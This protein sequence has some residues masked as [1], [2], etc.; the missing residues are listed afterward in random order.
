[1]SSKTTTAHKVAELIRAVAG[2]PNPKNYTS[3]VIL[4]A[5]SSVRMGGDKTKQFI[6]IDG[7]PTVARTLIEFEKAECIHEIII[8][9]KAGE[10]EL[11]TDFSEKYN[12][13]KPLRLVE[14]GET[15]Q[16]SAR[17]GSDVIND[18][19]KFICIHDAARCLITSKQIDKICH[20]AYLHKNAILALR[21]TDT[22]KIGDKS[23]FIESTTD[24]THTWQA[25]TPQV[26]SVNAYRGAAYIARDESFVATDDASMLEHIRIPV[27]LIDGSRE[28]IKITEPY[29]ILFAEAII[30]A[31]KTEQETEKTKQLGQ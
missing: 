28:N 2:K 16:D 20:E 19:A 22:I 6:E 1:M 11:Y 23:A 25:Q 18:K 4:A 8:V 15:R 21:A 29:D 14:G 5:G 13:K 27:K 31:R 30:R 10:E 3:A 9:I 17:I 7:I 26:F 12:L 24:R